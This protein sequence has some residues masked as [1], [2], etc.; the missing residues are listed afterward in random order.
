MI[1]K[2]IIL[3]QIDVIINVEK[4]IN[5]F[6]DGQSKNKSRKLDERYDSFDYCYNYFYSFYQENRIPELANDDNLQMSCFQLGFYLASWGMM[7]SSLFLF[8]K[9]V[10]HY[11]NLI[12]AI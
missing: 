5:T 2:I 1:I 3:L 11:K 12:I 9:S 10:R 8:E 4:F 6:L 7:R